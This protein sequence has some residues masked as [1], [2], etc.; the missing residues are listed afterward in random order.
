MMIVVLLFPLLLG[1]LCNAVRVR[2]PR[3]PDADARRAEAVNA[4]TLRVEDE[5]QKEMVIDAD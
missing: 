2:P 5:D 3:R 1:A 4:E